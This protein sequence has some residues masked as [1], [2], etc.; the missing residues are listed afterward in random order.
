MVNS[1]ISVAIMVESAMCD[2]NITIQNVTP[3]F[4]VFVN[5]TDPPEFISPLYKTV[6]SNA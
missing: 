1:K 4:E 6:T 2:G 3:N 5:G